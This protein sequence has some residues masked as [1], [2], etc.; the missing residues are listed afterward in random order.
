MQKV[1]KPVSLVELARS[2]NRQ[3]QLIIGPL[4][5][6]INFTQKLLFR[7]LVRYITHHDVSALFIARYHSLNTLI[8][9]QR[10][11]VV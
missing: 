5:R 6:L 11:L 8:I 2:I 4:V 1:H 10:C 7:V 9:D 3:V